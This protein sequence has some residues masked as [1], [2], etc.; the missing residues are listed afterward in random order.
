[1]VGVNR[2]GKNPGSMFDR[3]LKSENLDQILPET[4]ILIIS[5]PG[6]EATFHIVSEKQLKLLPDDAVVINVGRGSV[7]DQNALEKELR[8]GR[9][10]AGLDVFE[11]EPVPPE[12]S[13]WDCPRLIITPHV[14]GDLTLPYTV[15]KIVS[16]FLENLERY[17]AGEP[18][19]R[20]VDRKAGY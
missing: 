17:C 5:L 14:S 12:S 13:L 2:G 8:S 11:E 15:E 16:Q 19:L 3:V 6:T 7:V 4:D 9:L 20:V 10:Y 18:L 1:M